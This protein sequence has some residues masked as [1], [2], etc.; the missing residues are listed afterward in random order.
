MGSRQDTHE[1][2]T[3]A[4]APG[5]SR[6]AT[7]I[8]KILNTSAGPTPKHCIALNS[9]VQL[10]YPVTSSGPGLQARRP[11][12]PTHTTDENQPPAVD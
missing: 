12:A 10:G 2:L 1:T 3:T 11:P 7:L 9:C 8:D 6:P 4:P 5:T